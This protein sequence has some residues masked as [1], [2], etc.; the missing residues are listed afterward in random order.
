[1]TQ[2]IAVFLVAILLISLGLQTL[3]LADAN[4]SVSL[5]PGSAPDLT[6]IPPII[7]V[8][9]PQNGTLYN[10]S[11]MVLNFNVS[12][13]DSSPTVGSPNWW[14]S[15]AAD[16]I[17]GVGDLNTVLIDT[18]SSVAFKEFSVNLTSIPEGNHSVVVYVTSWLESGHYANSETATTLINFAIDLTP[19]QISSISVE[20]KTYNSLELP[21]NFVVDE[22]ISQASYV[23]DNQ[24][25]IVT[26]NNTTLTGLT[27]GNHNLTVYV[28]DSAG[29]IGES[30]TISFSVEAP[31]PLLL[32]A[33]MVSAAIV[34][35][36]A[37]AVF[38]KKRR[39]DVTD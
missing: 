3:H 32:T 34:V 37:A 18:Q 15:Y 39:Q 21:L 33:A 19:P 11:S 30:E 6:L 10:T 7:S 20:N 35:A 13:P 5:D 29:N 38:L 31:F 16:W 36:A 17:K 1:M 24:A 28:V 12:V 2:R 25:K 27:V 26:N 14:T 8:H 23:I 9:T 4:P 22:K